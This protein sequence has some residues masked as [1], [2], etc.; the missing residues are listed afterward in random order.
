MSRR[1]ITEQPVASPDTGTATRDLHSTP[2]GNGVVTRSHTGAQRWYQRLFVPYRLFARIPRAARICTLLAVLNAVCWSVITPPFEAPDEPAHI[3]YVQQLAETGELPSTREGPYSSQEEAAMQGVLLPSVLWHPEN[4]T[5]ATAAQQRSLQEY[6]SAPLARTDNGNAGVATSEPP[7]YYAIE[8]VPYYLGAGGNLLDS[9][10]LMRLASALMAGFT[11]LFIY[12]FARE[13]L[14]G[15]PWAWTV[16]GLSAALTPLLAFMSG[17]VNPDALLY[18][19]SAATFYCLARGFRRGLT[20]RLAVAIGAVTAAGLLTKVNYL[21]L[22][23]GIGVGVVILVSRA[24]RNRPLPRRFYISLAVAL[25][26]P[27][28]PVCAYVVKNLLAHQAALGLVSSGLSL[29]SSKVTFLGELR[30]L[31]E[32]YLPRIPGMTN[33][34]PGLFTTRDIWFN[35]SVGLYGWLDTT[36]PNWVDNLALIPFGL[37]AMLGLRS[38]LAGRAALRRRI[39]E[40][41]VYAVMALGL[42]VLLGGDSYLNSSAEGAGWAQPRYL[43]PLLPLL[44]VS[45]ALAARGAGRRWGPVAGTL[46]VV[47]ALAH[48]IFSQLQTVG[49]FYG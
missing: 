39:G 26:I 46:I 45:T 4:H 22:L 42:M 13:T 38:L 15:T 32:F 34:F 35:R 33:N 40:L 14:P 19:V 7:L 24:L 27:A 20:P 28:A 9:V 16:A 37:V 41:L 10:T 17:V 8:V 12:L 3:A 2:A 47:L 43:M 21:G 18:A 49:R 31:W 23:P 11:A 44:I 5:V 30:Y 25:A 1:P 29:T 36:F 48:D 6:L